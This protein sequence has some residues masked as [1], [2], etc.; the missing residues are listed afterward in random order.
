MADVRGDWEIVEFKPVTS[1]GLVRSSVACALSYATGGP[2]RGEGSDSF[3]GLKRSM[4]VGLHCCTLQA[5]WA[6]FRKITRHLLNNAGKAKEV[7]QRASTRPPEA[8]LDIS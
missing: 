8:Y 6:E 3:S 2:Q 1:K 7:C 4:S 5:Q